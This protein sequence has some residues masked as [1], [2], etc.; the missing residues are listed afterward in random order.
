[1][2]R[3]RK[4]PVAGLAMA[5]VVLSQWPLMDRSPLRLAIFCCGGVLVVALGLSERA[6][7]SRYVVGVGGVPFVVQGV[8]GVLSR[9]SWTGLVIGLLY[10]GLGTTVARYQSGIAPWGTPGGTTGN[11]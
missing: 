9:T 2:V 11:S 6:R 3:D 7:A 10:G 8:Y 1:M 4:T 5:V